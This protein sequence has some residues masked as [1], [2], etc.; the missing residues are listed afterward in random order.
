M[1]LSLLKPVDDPRP[2]VFM[3]EHPENFKFDQFRL[4]HVFPIERPCLEE[5]PMYVN[6][7]IDKSSS[8]AMNNELHRVKR[9]HS[10]RILRRRTLILGV[11]TMVTSRCSCQPRDYYYCFYELVP[12]NTFLK[13]NVCLEPKHDPCFDRKGPYVVWLVLQNRG[14]SGS[15]SN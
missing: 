13:K 9:Q 1:A 5:R 2:S 8:G 12:H 6:V 14:Y 11:K 7:S 3:T 10:K 15:S 4:R